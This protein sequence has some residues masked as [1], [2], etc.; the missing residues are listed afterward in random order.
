MSPD[1]KEPLCPLREPAKKNQTLPRSKG[2]VMRKFS[3]PLK[4]IGRHVLKALGLLVAGV[5]L[6]ANGPMAQAAPKP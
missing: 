5:V 2:D 4:S 3:N 1:I 6:L